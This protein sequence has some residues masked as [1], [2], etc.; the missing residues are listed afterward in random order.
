M[1]G[2]GTVWG[3]VIGALIM[4]E[5]RFGLNVLGMSPFIQQI[6][7]G[8]ILIAAVYLDTVRTTRKA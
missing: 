7:V 6:V 5:I 2:R 8:V 1:G 4:S 3:A